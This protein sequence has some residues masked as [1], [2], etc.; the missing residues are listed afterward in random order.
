MN[1]MMENSCPEKKASQ[2]KYLGQI[3]WAPEP[4]FLPL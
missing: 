3:I 2:V 4:K 1:K